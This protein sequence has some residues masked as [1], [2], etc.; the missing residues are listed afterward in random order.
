MVVALG[1]GGCALDAMETGD[2]DPEIEEAADAATNYKIQ[3]RFSRT[4]S[5]SEYQVSNG[6]TISAA[7]RTQWDRPRD[8]KRPTIT[9]SLTKLNRL[10]DDTIGE[11][12][13]LM[14]AKTVK[15][16]WPALK[17]GKYR[18]DLGSANSNPYCVV[19]G[20]MDVNITP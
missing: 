14:N 3:L 2:E 19:A 18:I 13:H 11:V 5:S 4:F 7:I 10:V 9:L 8:C 16:S 20:T 17:A 12:P 15:Y 1:C 6:G